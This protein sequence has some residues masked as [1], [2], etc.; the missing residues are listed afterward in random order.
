MALRAACCCA[1]DDCPCYIR[2]INAVCHLAGGGF[3]TPC[4]AGG[5]GSRLVVSPPGCD[6]RTAFSLTQIEV[7]QTLGVQNGTPYLVDAPDFRSCFQAPTLRTF[8][9]DNAFV[10]YFC[11][12][13]EIHNETHTT[14]PFTVQFPEP[15]SGDCEIR[16]RT[17]Y[18]EVVIDA[19][20]C[21]DCVEALQDTLTFN[22]DLIGPNIEFL[23]FWHDATG[24]AP[25]TL[26]C[27]KEAFSHASEVAPLG[28]FSADAQVNT[29]SPSQFLQQC[30]ASIEVMFADEQIPLTQCSP[31]PN[32]PF[33]A[34][35]RCTV[36]SGFDWDWDL[37]SVPNDPA[38][39]IG[40]SPNRVSF[41]NITYPVYPRVI[42][43]F[44]YG[45]NHWYTI[46]ATPLFIETPVIWNGSDFEYPD[47]CTPPAG[48]GLDFEYLPEANSDL[49]LCQRLRAW[50]R[51]IAGTCESK[52]TDIWQPQIGWTGGSSVAWNIS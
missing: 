10:Q 11:D 9:F 30:N 26:V 25:E 49:Q 15:C 44:G 24:Q 31:D 6:Q 45:Y 32:N 40:L 34:G 42:R 3:C 4:G 46:Y 41:A 22:L 51:S 48:G 36:G 1:P 47:R 38:G 35:V 20:S 19:V 43:G 28:Q 8:R 13:Q 37:S 29:N 17:H 23:D 12:G 2:Y 50:L 27:F 33:T 52:L 18:N 16:I 5:G 39:P 7:G 21:T 14:D